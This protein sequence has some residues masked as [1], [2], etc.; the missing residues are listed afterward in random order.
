MKPEFCHI[1]HNLRQDLDVSLPS[2]ER[3][4]LFIS[5]IKDIY[6]FINTFSFF[7]LSFFPDP[8]PVI[9]RFKNSLILDLKS[10]LQICHSVL[11]SIS[12]FK[13]QGQWFHFSS[14]IILDPSADEWL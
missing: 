7:F 1:I 9:I 2:Q 3:I 5:G 13:N 12:S 14:C 6:L 8:V 4:S 10:Q 11:Q